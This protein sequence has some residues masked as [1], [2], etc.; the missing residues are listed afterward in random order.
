[1]RIFCPAIGLSRPSRLL[2][3][4]L[5]W[6]VLVGSCCAALP[7]PS[8]D[9]RG[10]AC[11]FASNDTDRDPCAC[12]G[13]AQSLVWT[14]RASWFGADA[15]QHLSHAGDAIQESSSAM[16][17]GTPPEQ[18]EQFVR[19]RVAGQIRRARAQRAVETSAGWGRA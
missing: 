17:P 1:M 10:R 12:C 13:G 11:R 6:V 3:P 2:L 5:V 14:D 18:P 7:P 4:R 19:A 8:T 9:P 15:R 16:H